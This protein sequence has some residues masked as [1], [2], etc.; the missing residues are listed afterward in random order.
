[1]AMTSAADR[2]RARRCRMKAGKV[3]LAIVVDEVAVEALLLEAGLL[4]QC[5]PTREDLARGIEKFL[6]LAVAH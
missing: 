1:M 4:R 2:Q 5:D 6:D 3:R